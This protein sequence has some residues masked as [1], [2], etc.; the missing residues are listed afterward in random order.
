MKAGAVLVDGG[1][2]VAH[3]L[4]P[5]EAEMRVAMSLTGCTRLRDITGG[6][7]LTQ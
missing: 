5:I 3:V 1:A 4:A 2:G 6:L 7:L